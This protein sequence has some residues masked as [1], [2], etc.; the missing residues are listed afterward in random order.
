MKV[1]SAGTYPGPAGESAGC[2]ACRSNRAVTVLYGQAV[3]RLVTLQ[4]GDVRVDGDEVEL[5]LGEEWLTVPEPFAVLL[6]AHMRARP[7]LQTAS[8]RESPWVFP[9]YVPRLHLDPAHVRRALGA[10]GMPARASRQAT[11]RKIVWQA[12]P[13][14]LARALGIS[15]STAAHHA[16]LAGATT[17]ISS[18]PG[19]TPTLVLRRR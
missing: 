17:A 12:R 16:E 7:N 5:R 4:I 3:Q 10:A 18:L 13:A 8:H 11:W 1:P 2:G 9:G 15:T 6:S 14:V 19:E